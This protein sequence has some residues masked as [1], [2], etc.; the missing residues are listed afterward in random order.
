MHTADHLDAH[1]Q[2][3]QHVKARHVKASVVNRVVALLRVPQSPG[4]ALWAADTIT[5]KHVFL[6]YIAFAYLITVSGKC[7]EKKGNSCKLKVSWTG[8]CYFLF[9]I[10]FPHLR[11]F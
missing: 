1:S 2:A 10:I 7:F 8:Q 5:Y 6:E 11:K 4:G 9:G 3:D